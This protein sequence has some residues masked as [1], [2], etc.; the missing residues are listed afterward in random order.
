MGAYNLFLLGQPGLAGP[1][2]TIRLAGLKAQALLWYL[3]AQPDRVFSRSHLAALLWENDDESG[4]RNSLGTTLTRLRKALPVWPLRSDGDVLGWDP[5]AGVRV[6]TA[7]FLELTRGLAAPGGRLLAEA[8]SLWR[9]PFL[10]GFHLPANEAY[11]QW[12]RL[13]RQQWE[14]R[15]LAAL[16]A[17][18]QAELAEGAWEGAI[19]HSRQALAIDPLQERFHQSLMAA[20]YHSGD[21]AAALSQYA[22]CR[23]VLQRELGVEPDA[24]TTSLRDAI[25][26][27]ELP[28]RLPPAGAGSPAAVGAPGQRETDAPAGAAPPEPL[29]LPPAVPL[30]GREAQLGLVTAALTRAA[31]EPGRL[32]L[33]HGEAG[34]GKSRLVEEVL[35]QTRQGQ[36]PAWRTVLVGRCHEA[37]HALPYAPFAEALRGVF[38][39]LDLARLELP[40]LWLTE[41]S[42]LLP[43][44]CH[45]RPGLPAPA[46]LHP[47]QEQGRL[48]EAVARLVSALPGPLLLILE[49]LHWAD[50]ATWQLLAYLVRRPLARG[51]GILATARAGEL[52]A[53][54][55]RLLQGLRR[56]GRLDWHEVPPL[57]P[58][59]IQS[60]VALLAGR[61]YRE[62]GARLHAETGGNALYAV[63]LLRTLQGSGLL[64]GGAAGLLE[65]LPL[66]PSVQAAVRERL[67][68]LPGPAVDLVNAAA[69]F[70]AGAAFPVLQQVAGL[71]EAAA[72]GALDRLLA[73]A[74]LREVEEVHPP[75]ALPA[76]AGVGVPPR[77]AFSHDLIRR[78]V[79]AGLSQTR[80]QALH[81]RAYAALA[82]ADSPAPPLAEQLATHAAAGGLWEAGAV[83]SQ[84]A[85]AAAERLVAFPAAARLL[86]QALACL[87]QLP[88]TPERR[89]QAIDIRLQLA[90]LGHFFHPGRQQEWLVP[91]VTEA[92]ALGDQG[93]LSQVW[94][95]RFEAL[96]VQGR[97]KRAEPIVG[98]LLPAIRA[99]GSQA[100]LAPCLTFLGI[101]R[102]IRGEF[103]AAAASL[104]EAIPLQ[105]GH[106]RPVM[107]VAARSALAAVQA[108]L[109]EFEQAEAL[110][111]AAERLIRQMGDR[112]L[113]AHILSI[114]AT[115]A[116]YRG[117]RDAAASASREALQQA[118]AAEHRFHEY[119]ATVCLGVALSALGDRTGAVAVL[120]QAVDLAGRAR[121]RLLLDRVHGWLAEA[122]LAAGEMAAAETAIR[123]GL[124]LA[125]TDGLQY[126]IALC[127]R[128]QGQIAAARA[129]PAEARALLQ[130]AL[131]RFAGLGARP[132]AARCHS[133]LA[134]LPAGEAERLRH[135][136]Q[137]EALFQSMGMLRDLERLAHG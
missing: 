110:A 46:A 97:L 26:R 76:A 117:D 14:N 60:L 23:R 36:G 93:R 19:G 92:S 108:I 96:I 21:R 83:W 56:E 127:T 112:A 129:R 99:S 137:A 32:I 31:G 7:R 13:E 68:R 114:F 94:I 57:S 118:R 98:R 34:S 63:E 85:A 9:G 11:D 42:R 75:G 17:L 2:G 66:P 125:T 65:R 132:D 95:A 135:R 102:S 20:C 48:F 122:R 120:E 28:R 53:D 29:P 54:L 70:P 39:A 79:A 73:A 59:A 71:E 126:G 62:L 86:E 3:A 84:A 44:L 89:R 24:A 33:L 30:V 103:R 131:G 6:D 4:R 72:L 115:I 40:D 47:G 61:E 5:A 116:H 52:P 35:W 107:A 74:V 119:Y 41:L 81:R 88:A 101:L 121:T 136:Q 22:E 90:R 91:A 12:L 1:A 49:D 25:A 109:G 50:A 104:G 45:A 80:Q 51:C 87:K 105:D 38:P 128:V 58:E 10:D 69:I 130:D 106:G 43:E 27:G 82:Q 123:T 113:T 111:E 8:V 16:G 77:V 100:L 124:A 37:A 134:G 64:S 133:L 55:D 15:V 67:G 78:A 18:V